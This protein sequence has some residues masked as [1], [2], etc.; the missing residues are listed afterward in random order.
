M[1]YYTVSRCKKGQG[2]NEAKSVNNSS[3]P[4]DKSRALADFMGKSSLNT[5]ETND[6][7]HMHLKDSMKSWSKKNT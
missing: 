4:K 3:V 2:L 1:A 7:C 6:Y 5:L